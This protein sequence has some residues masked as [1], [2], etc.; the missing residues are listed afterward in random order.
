MPPRYNRIDDHNALAIGAPVRLYHSQAE[1]FLHASCD[2]DKNRNKT[3]TQP[4][5]KG[6][7]AEDGCDEGGWMDV[8]ARF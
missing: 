5:G 8:I 2:P 1:S 6:E 7:E 4:D 3:R